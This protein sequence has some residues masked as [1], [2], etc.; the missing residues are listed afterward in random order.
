M[1]LMHKDIPVADITVYNG[2]IIS[3]NRI[4]NKEH[5]PIGAYT[6]HSQLS[7][8]FLDNWSKM[9]C[10]PKDRQNAGEIIRKIGCSLHEAIYKSNGVSLTDCYWFKD[11]NDSLSWKDVNYFDNK[12]SETYVENVLSESGN[13]YYCYR[14]DI[15]YYKYTHPEEYNQN[16]K[17][18]IKIPG[19]VDDGSLEKYWNSEKY[20]KHR[21]IKPN[22]EINFKAPDFVT[23]G[24]LE[25]Y[26]TYTDY[27]FGIKQGSEPKNIPILIKFGNLGE[28]VQNKNLLSANE[29]IASDLYVHKIMNI[30]CVDYWPLRLGDQTVCGCRS[31]VENDNMEFVNALQLQ[32]ESIAK[33]KTDLR[34]TFIN[35]GLG[36][37]LN[38][39]MVFDFIIGNTD[40]H[41]KN[42]GVIRNPNTLEIISVAPLFDNG[43]SLGWDGEYNINNI[44]LKPFNMKAVDVLSLINLNSVE[45]PDPNEICGLI[46]MIYYEQFSIYTEQHIEFV[47][48]MVRNN[49]DYLVK[50]RMRHKI[51][52]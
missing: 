19:F 25:K 31:F 7:A 46:N 49:I 52:T 37:F 14:N 42:F 32:K 9:R 17:I 2:T 27:F 41:E 23:D 47:K 11:N 51:Y 35:M 21:L 48:Q 34:T 18:E 16:D 44:Y 38:D 8:R 39:M 15:N 33:N 13:E 45:I 24:A 50:E 1:I 30:P 5:Y 26:W 22:E 20:K 6:P 43:T 12:F 4:Y 29:V 36:K 40:R 10:I 3:V 28:V